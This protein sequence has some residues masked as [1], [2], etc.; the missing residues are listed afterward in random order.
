[1]D[2]KKW[3]RARYAAKKPVNLP[4]VARE[5]SDILEK[6]FAGPKPRGWRR[7]LIERKMDLCF[8]N[9]KKHH[10]GLYNVI[11]ATGWGRERLVTLPRPKGKHTVH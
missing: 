9:L 2:I 1:M 10:L 7:S 6:V 4:A 5:R 3:I 11:S 8:S